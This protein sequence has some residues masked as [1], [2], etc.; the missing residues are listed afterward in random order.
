MGS[1]ISRPLILSQ[2]EPS[3][4]SRFDGKR[5]DSAT[6]VEVRESFCIGYNMCA[7]SYSRVASQEAGAL[8]DQAE[9]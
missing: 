8:T 6:L 5:P 3:R 4:I 9:R 7:P 1:N 2:L